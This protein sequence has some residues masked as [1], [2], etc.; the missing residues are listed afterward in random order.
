MSS[1]L[2]FSG[3]VARQGV[4]L[5]FYKVIGNPRYQD[6]DHPQSTVGATDA[7]PI[8]CLQCGRPHPRLWRA[9][10]K[11]VGL[12]GCWVVFRYNGQENVPDLSIPIAVLTI[13]KGA[14]PCTDAEN[15]LLWHRP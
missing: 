8:P 7:D 11:P 4:R 6:A 14:V 1:L 2:Q 9:Y 15:S 3:E 12:C 13:P 5:E 10:R